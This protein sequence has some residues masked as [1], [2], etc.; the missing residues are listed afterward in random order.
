MF[1]ILALH[2]TSYRFILLLSIMILL[3]L[4]VGRFFERK[5][6]PNLTGY[7]LIGLLF[8]ALVVLTGQTEIISAF[9]VL[10]NI[11]IG[12]IAF[13]IGLELNFKKIKNRSREVFI[14]TFFQAIFAFGLTFLALYILVLPLHIAL[15]I[16]SLAIATEPGPIL[17]ITKKLHAHGPLT[18]TLVPLHGVEDGITIFIFG[19]S[20]SYALSIETGTAFTFSEILWGPIAEIFFSVVIAIAIGY[21][22][23]RII[24]FLKYED[25]EKDLVVLVTA[26]VAIM[27]SIA[28]ANSGFELFNHHIHL[29]PILLPMVAGITFSNLSSDLAKHET[30]HSIDQFSG[31]ILIAFFTILGAEIVILVAQ[32]ISIINL[33]LIVSAV[34]IYVVFRLFGKLLGSYLGGKVAKSK[35][36][37][38]KYLG[39][40]LLPQAQAAI[41]LAFY[42]HTQFGA[43]TYGTVILVTILIASVINELFGPLGLRYAVT[44]CNGRDGQSCEI[45]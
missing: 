19:V 37:V 10:I 13:S 23:M 24:K 5:K 43:N 20:L 39:F 29:S 33:W 6:I 21:V 28:I 3:G 8:G 9:S 11:A 31:P 35:P 15:L 38:R 26:F 22:F 12:F 40:C 44:H 2:T 25:A 32:S 4:F 27:I 14:V 42:A 36:I 34:L 41:G 18:D 7:V 17:L 30:E 1:T 16:G 45:L